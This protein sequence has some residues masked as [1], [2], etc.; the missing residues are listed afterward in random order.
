MFR[1][2]IGDDEPPARHAGAG[3]AQKEAIAETGSTKTESSAGVDP[4]VAERIALPLAVRL[5]PSPLSD[6]DTFTRNQHLAA[7]FAPVF[8][9]LPVGPADPP[10][11]S[12]VAD[13]HPSAVDPFLDKAIPWPAHAK[14]VVPVVVLAMCLLVAVAVTVFVLSFRWE[15]WDGNGRSW[16]AIGSVAVV[17]AASAKAAGMAGSLGRFFFDRSR[18]GR[19]SDNPSAALAKFLWSS[20]LIRRLGGIAGSSLSVSA[21]SRKSWSHYLKAESRP[22]ASY[23]RI[24]D[25]GPGLVIQYWQFYPY[26]DFANQHECD[27]EVVMLFFNDELDPVAAAY[28]IHG[29][30]LWRSWDDVQKSGEHP[31][32]YVALLGR[33]AA[34][35]RPPRRGRP[36]SRLHAARRPVAGRDARFPGL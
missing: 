20:P 23:V 2:R 16:W 32:C 35:D 8:V 9:T 5:D 27:W 24:D 26:N 12:G 22:R 4:P 19:S 33:S 15:S 18:F 11:P 34:Y 6:A 10:Y 29:G 7:R 21:D 28:S 36:L 13:Y 17:I 14:A 25:S 31:V 3:D 30:G 1:W